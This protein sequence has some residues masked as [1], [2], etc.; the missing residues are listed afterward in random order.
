KDCKR[1]AEVDFPIAQV[2][3][4]SLAEKARRF[5]TPHQLH[6]WWSWKP[7]AAC[8]AM[9]LGLLWPDPCD[10]QCPDSFKQRARQLL[11]RVHGTVGHRDR[12]LQ[13]ALLRFIGDF[14]DWDLGM[15]SSYLEISRELV[16]AAHGEETPLVVDPFAGGG[17]ISLEALRL[18]CEAFASDLNP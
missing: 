4:H 5:G 1:L 10:P 13:K 11:G 9:L 8:R 17:S 6:M 12:D 16:E 18:G 3:R 15:S 7:L 14:A 2:S